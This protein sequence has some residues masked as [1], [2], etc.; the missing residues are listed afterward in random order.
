MK[1]YNN[2]GIISANKI[3]PTLQKERESK[4]EFSEVIEASNRFLHLA[5]AASQDGILGWQISADESGEFSCVAFTGTEVNVTNEDFNWAF[6]TIA[7]FDEYR[8][9]FLENLYEG[10]R[11]V[12]ALTRNS[13]Q[14]SMQRLTEELY[15]YYDEDFTFQPVY[16]FTELVEMLAE[17]GAVIRI[18]ADSSKDVAGHGPILISFPDNISLRLRSMFAIALPD[19][20]FEDVSED[21]SNSSQLVDGAMYLSN[22]L[23][24][25]ILSNL[26]YALIR[27]P[28]K[29]V[30]PD[31]QCEQ[32]EDAASSEVEEGDGRVPS[33]KSGGEA[34]SIDV[35]DLSPRAYNCLKRAG[36]CTIDA[37]RYMSE[38][39]L[40]HV[41][42][43]G[44]KSIAEIKDKL[45]KYSLE[46]PDY[47]KISLLS[48]ASYYDM[49]D[50]LIGLQEVKQQIR[51]IAAFAKMKQ[52]ISSNSDKM[53]SV[54]L[55]MEFIGNPGTAK[56]TVARIA[57]GIFHEIGLL[58][59]K[60][61]LEVGRADLIG[62]YEGQTAIKVKEVFSKAKGKMLFI[63][64]AYSLAECWEGAYGD[65][66]IAT[67]VQEMENDRE[68]TIVVFAGYP[69]KMKALFDRNPG[70]RSRVPFSV[71]FDDYSADEMLEIVELEA[72]R[73]GF[74]VEPEAA[75][76]VTAIC[77]TVAGDPEGGN[78][79]FCRNLVEGAILEYALRNYGGTKEPTSADFL[80]RAEDFLIPSNVK[81]VRK[82]QPIGF[83]V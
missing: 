21:D 28:G 37:L 57:A 31:K 44:R 42:N 35:L 43:L 72:K 66:A 15:G 14:T 81:N 71:R 29:G 11:K 40:H 25:S 59:S 16:C 27:R 22:D 65:E 12:Y 77:N 49:L 64:E 46:Y 80:L 33:E 69:D 26:L 41:R 45:A 18:I 60:E 32:K 75:K 5:E 6:K 34:D 50:E 23:F 53:M 55:N 76:K 74:G 68:D 79:R 63:D 70:L 38:E 36:I 58:S 56:T 17:A 3:M 73:R 20:G 4:V 39:D 52:A 9:H 82:A 48:T 19:M 51:K 8:G 24:R 10:N 54:V 83:A 67:I 47:E 61:M 13:D 30:E 78:G 7:V 2:V 1:D 62:K